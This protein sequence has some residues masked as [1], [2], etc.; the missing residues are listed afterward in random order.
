MRHGLGHV[1]LNLEFFFSFLSGQM[2]SARPFAVV[3]IFASQFIATLQTDD[4][5][6]PLGGAGL[7]EEVSNE[8][9]SFSGRRHSRSRAVERDRGGR[10]LQRG[11]L[12][13]SDPAVDHSGWSGASR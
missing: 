7:H 3:F 8:R 10:V 13:R 9:T 2:D 6:P 4:D 1:K 12:T 5:S 11:V